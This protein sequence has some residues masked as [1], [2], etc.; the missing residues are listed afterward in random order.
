MKYNKRRAYV[1]SCS[2]VFRRRV[3]YVAP[4]GP[5]IKS[6][7]LYRMGGSDLYFSQLRKEFKATMICSPIQAERE[8]AF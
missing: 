2:T 3:T 7:L 6:S 5:W 8:F 1:V 4:R